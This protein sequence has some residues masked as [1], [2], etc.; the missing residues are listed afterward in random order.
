MRVESFI[1]LLMQKPSSSKQLQNKK[2]LNKSNNKLHQLVKVP[3]AQGFK[4]QTKAPQVSNLQNSSDGSVLVRH[5][6]YL[7][8]IQGSALFVN[9]SYWIQPAV[10]V[11]FPWLSSIAARYEQYQFRKLKFCYETEKPT[12]AGG[13]IMLAIDFDASDSAAQ[14]KASLMSYH[15]AQRAP[16]W[17][18]CTVICDSKNLLN[19]G[20]KR[21]TRLGSLAPHQDVKTYDLGTLQVATQGCLDSSVIGELYVEYEV[22][23]HTPQI[24]YESELLQRGY[25]S[26][27]NGTRTAP[28]QTLVSTSGNLPLFMTPLGVIFREPGS[29]WIMVAVTGTV[30]NPAAFPTVTIQAG[31]QLA[32]GAIPCVNSTATYAVYQYIFKSNV[33][34]SYIQFS[35]LNMTTLTNIYTRI[36]SY[37]YLT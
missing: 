36:S 3:A 19:F 29:W 5:R 8:D 7:K 13:S 6:E 4:N 28:Y 17:S 11:L 35:F 20:P 31:D 2:N 37:P 10:P 16:V 26:S 12:S 32:S 34:E 27:Y 14:S 22:E 9:T 24:D 30:I 15:G 18:S 21:F 23:L 25:S 1:S 33:T